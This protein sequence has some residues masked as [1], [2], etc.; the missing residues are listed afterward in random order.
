MRAQ[1]NRSIASNAHDIT[2]Q[3][4]FITSAVVVVVAT[5]TA[6]AKAVAEAEAVSTA[7]TYR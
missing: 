5:T 2:Q 7:A 1:Y 6:A 4:Q 3:M